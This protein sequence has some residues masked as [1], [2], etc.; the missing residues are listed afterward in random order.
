MGRD[1]LLHLIRL[2][3]EKDISITFDESGVIFTRHRNGTMYKQKLPK[4]DI[5]FFPYPVSNYFDK[6]IEITAEMFDAACMKEESH[7][8]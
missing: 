3:E 5:Y 6:Q 8:Y 4:N 2:C 7:G 1:D